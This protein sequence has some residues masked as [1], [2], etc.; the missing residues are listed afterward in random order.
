MVASDAPG[1]TALPAADQLS[2]TGFATLVDRLVSVFCVATLVPLVASGYEQLRS[3][4]ARWLA[5]VGGTLVATS[6]LMPLYAWN[7]RGIRRHQLQLDDV[8]T[9][10]A[11][12]L[13]VAEVDRAA[14]S[15]APVRDLVGAFGDRG[16]DAAL[17]QP[18]PV[19][20]RRISLVREHP[21]RSRSRV[22][23][24]G[25][26]DLVEHVGEH[27]RVCDL[28]AGQYERE[29]A[30]LPVAHEVDLRRQTAP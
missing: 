1:A 25:D 23:T 3:L 14:R 30:G 9:L 5:V 28:T 22:A 29:C 26:V 16:L 20:L 17:A 11:F 19:L 10:V 15:L 27:T 6:V 2:T 13:L 18:G 24:P 7:R 8:A 21:V 12:L 4:D